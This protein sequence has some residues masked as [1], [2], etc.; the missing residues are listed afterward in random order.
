MQ[1]L[2]LDDVY[3]IVPTSFWQTPVGYGILIV[4]GILI[5]AIFAYIV[6]LLRKVSTADQAIKELRI[7]EKES[8]SKRLYTELTAVIKRYLGWRYGILP[9][10]TDYELTLFLEEQGEKEMERI[11]TDAQTVK[12]GYGVV[13]K[14]AM[15]KDIAHS[16]AF[17][18]ATA[19]EER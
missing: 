6:I 11:I 13:L 8:D 10:V 18:E 12:F 16:I 2:L 5:I 4:T 19:K 7:L 17:I 9:S 1:E 14:D 3:D 15:K